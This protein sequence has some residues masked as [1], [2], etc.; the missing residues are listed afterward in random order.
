MEL[1]SLIISICSLLLSLITFIVYDKKIKKQN[2]ILNQYQIQN[3]EEEKLKKKCAKISGNIIKEH[4]GIRKLIIS[5]EGLAPARNIC[6][7]DILDYKGIILTRTASI[8]FELLNPGEC[9]EVQF[10]ISESAPD[11]IKMEY[12]WDDDYKNH[13][14]YRQNLQL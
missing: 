3:I 7:T 12:T 14:I 2:L 5:N 10:M 13:N 4:R 11:I 9:F 1:V 6:I 8:P